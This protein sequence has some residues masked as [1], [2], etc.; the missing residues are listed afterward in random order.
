MANN[1]GL[2]LAHNW[3]WGGSVIKGDDGT[4]HM[5]VMHLVD[6]CGIQC[7]QTNG[8][9]LHATASQPEGPF[10]VK[11]VAITPRPGDKQ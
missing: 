11:G 1:S 10:D 2:V 4:Y 5:F 9:V 7:Y 3:T 8:Q 6:H